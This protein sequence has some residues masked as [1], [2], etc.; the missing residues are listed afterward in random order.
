MLNL[1]VLLVDDE[2]EMREIVA[3][4]LEI[5]PFF[6][7][8]ACATGAQALT[9]AAEW[10]P[11]LVLLDVAMPDMDGPTVLSR[12]HA[13]RRTA[14]IPVVFL[15]PERQARRREKWMALGAAGVIAKPFDPVALA[16]ALRRFVA[17]EGVLAPA[18]EDFLQR[19]KADASALAAY[20]RHLAHTRR[21]PALMRIY[22]IAHGLAGAG[23]TYGFAGI[24]CESVALSAA[25][26]SNL[27]GHA[28][29]IEVERAL[30]RLLERIE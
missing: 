13:D 12:L 16:A 15:V 11:D 1:H 7:L 5:D 24:T 29:P 22:E 4:A 26:E 17:V 8:R 6:I 19:L 28:R 25:A 27:A 2:P 10:R 20:R 18:R 14:P 3:A 9:A 30:D 23:G 21:Q